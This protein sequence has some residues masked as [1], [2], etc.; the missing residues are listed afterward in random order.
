MN[1]V[2]AEATVG[3]AAG[4]QRFYVRMAAIFVAVAVVGFAPTYWVPMLRGTLDVPPFAHL[5][6]AV[7]YGW[8][9]LFLKQTLLAASG[10]VARHRELGVAGV[11]LATAM[12]LVGLGLSVNSLRRFEAAG[13]SESG[14]AF[15]IVSVS[16]ITLFAALFTVAVFNVRRPDVH[17][18]FMLV[19]TASLL[20]AA[21]ARW[22]VYFL[23]PDVPAGAIV[24]PPS[25]NVTVLPAILVD[26][27]IVWAMLHD[28]RTIGHVHRTYWIAG[29]A[30]VATQIL[31]VP[32][33]STAAWSH[34]AGWL[35]ALAP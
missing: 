29:A 11:A 14:R 26:L 18:R 27:L 21:V 4:S 23:A 10:R 24:P 35:L 25:I 6:A 20:Q 3:V 22:F 8:T 33:S 12:L 15:A 30:V 28:R 32:L 31:R 19:A 5:H 13:L 16:A 17:K 34:V 7:F 2:V 1:M 9:L